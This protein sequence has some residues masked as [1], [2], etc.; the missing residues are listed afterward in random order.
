MNL[1]KSIASEHNLSETALSVPT[2]LTYKIRWFMPICEVN[3][4]SHAT[5]AA[6]FVLF[7]ILEYEQNK[8][9]FS[10]KSGT[11]IVTKN[12]EWLEMDFPAQPPIPEQILNAFSITPIACLK[13]E[14]YIVVF[15]DEQNILT[16]KPYLSLLSQ[17]DLRRVVITAKEVILILLFGVSYQNMASMK[18]LLQVLHSP[19][20]FRIG[21]KT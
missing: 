1:C 21:Q 9:Q 19:S 5:L 12:K 18:I 20:L 14:D 17:L 10:S 13:S 15:K 4:C 11:L 16:A 7:N 2:G 6:A 8:I 3:L